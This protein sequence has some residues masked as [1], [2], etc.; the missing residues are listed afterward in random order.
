MTRLVLR[1]SGCGLRRVRTR[2]SACGETDL[3]NRVRAIYDTDLAIAIASMSKER[4]HLAR[5]PQLLAVSEFT[6]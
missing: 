6:Q 3:W 5:P 1:A 2:G 4:A